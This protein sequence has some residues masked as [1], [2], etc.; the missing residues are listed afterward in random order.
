MKKGYIFQK[1]KVMCLILFVFFFLL[2]DLV[3]AHHKE[4]K[5]SLI[6]GR[7]ANDAFWK[8]VEDFMRAACDDLGMELKVYYARGS[9]SKMKSI[10]KKS[11]SEKPDALVFSNIKKTAS[12]IIQSSEKSKV[13][14]FLF[15]GGIADENREKVGHPREKYKY[16]IGEML[17][18]DEG[19]GFDL[20]NMLIDAAKGKVGSDGKVHMVGINGIVSDMGAIERGK[21]LN[22]AVQARDDVVLHQVVP[23]NW[24]QAK[25]RAQVKKLMKRYPETSVFWASSDLMSVGII[26]GAQQLSLA[27]RKDIFTAGVDWASEGIKSVEAG[28]MNAT[29]GGHFMEGGWVAV[30]LYDYFHGID[31][32]DESLEMRSKM[33]ILTKDNVGSYI[34]LFGEGDWSEIDF[35]Q[36]SKKLN[37]EVKKY[38]FGLEAIMKQF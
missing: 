15:N 16:W 36:F 3:Y 26:E 30:V 33:S 37:P 19:A 31:F 5:I 29:A 22:R 21:G 7:S 9:R 2:G 28:M 8:P 4:I 34:Q 10:A 23:A 38:D 17:P 1:M 18:D 11:G 25:A 6:T 20:A 14:M 24:E 35:K 27:P 13:T 32:V 12:Q